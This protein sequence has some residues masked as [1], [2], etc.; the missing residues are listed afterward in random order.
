MSNDPTSPPGLSPE[1]TRQLVKAMLDH[2]DK[3]RSET[4]RG[5]LSDGSDDA[6]P[7]GYEQAARDL[8]RAAGVE[9]SGK[10]TDVAPGQRWR[11]AGIEGGLEV[12]AVVRGVVDHVS[13]RRDGVHKA[14]VTSSAADMLASPHWK[15]VRG[16]AE[17]ES[18]SARSHMVEVSGPAGDPIW[19]DQRALDF[20]A[21][22][23]R[24]ALAGIEPRK[25]V[26]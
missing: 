12:S 18:L 25:G 13:L 19:V 15:F 24:A 10:P 14:D 8:A 7:N 9:V 5:G 26:R 22:A 3:L 21:R 17:A 16:E 20:N 6:Y 11:R 1:R 4:H 23:A 2:A